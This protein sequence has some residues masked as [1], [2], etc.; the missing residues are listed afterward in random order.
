MTWGHAPA[1]ELKPPP[2]PGLATRARGP[3]D[4]ETRRTEEPLHPG[5][6]RCTPWKKPRGPLVVGGG[7]N[8]ESHPEQPTPGHTGGSGVRG[9]R[10]PEAQAP[11]LAPD[12]SPVCKG[13][14]TTSGPLLD[15]AAFDAKVGALATRELSA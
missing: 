4:P 13:G 10:S 6:L 12:L 8:C 9:G 3:K 5:E 7:G 14:P 11:L 2:P 1:A 15:L